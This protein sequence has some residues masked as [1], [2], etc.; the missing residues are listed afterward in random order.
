MIVTQKPL[1]LLE[2]F[3]IAQ[4]R[5]AKSLSL[6]ARHHGAGVREYSIRGLILSLLTEKHLSVKL[7]AWFKLKLKE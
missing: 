7:R 1:E 4:A 3:R 6:S 2:N 5:E